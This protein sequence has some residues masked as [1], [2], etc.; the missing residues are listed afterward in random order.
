MANDLPEGVLTTLLNQAV[1]THQFLMTESQGNIQHGNNM[2]RAISNKMLD[3]LD[4]V[5]SQANRALT[6]T[7]IG[8]PTTSA[9]NSSSGGA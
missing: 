7:P 6:N 2:L 5:E 8:A 3:Q 4:S 9:G 1:Q